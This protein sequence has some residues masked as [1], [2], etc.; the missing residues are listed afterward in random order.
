MVTD[1]NLIITETELIE[2]KK[3]Y[4][5]FSIFKK[6]T[7]EPFINTLSGEIRRYMVIHKK[8]MYMSK[9][10]ENLMLRLSEVLNKHK[11]GESGK[12]S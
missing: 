9:E 4:A 12:E 2:L 1:L 5:E 6:D 3:I 10:S 7:L 8:M 11:G